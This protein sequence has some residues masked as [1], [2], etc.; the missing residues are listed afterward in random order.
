M[1][2]H[3]EL[4]RAQVLSR[5]F[6][7]TEWNAEIRDHLKNQSPLISDICGIVMDYFEGMWSDEIMCIWSR[8]YASTDNNDELSSAIIDFVRLMRAPAERRD[9]SDAWKSRIDFTGNIRGNNYYYWE[10]CDAMM[11]YPRDDAGPE[12]FHEIIATLGLD[13]SSSMMTLDNEIANYIISIYNACEYIDPNLTFPFYT[14][15]FEE[16]NAIYILMCALM[17]QHHGVIR[18]NMPVWDPI[19]MRFVANMWIP[20]KLPTK[21]NDSIIC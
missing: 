12:I 15:H 8:S 9:I 14:I 1:S 4:T 19:S 6:L 20:A 2:V 16:M 7:L 18:C 11:K 13:V 3:P 10:Y 5:I 21:F 17:Q